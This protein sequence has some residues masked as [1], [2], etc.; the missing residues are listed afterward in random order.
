M[1]CALEELF[2]VLPITFSSFSL[3]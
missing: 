3:S 1:F 2:E